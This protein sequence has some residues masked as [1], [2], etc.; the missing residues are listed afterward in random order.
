VL[1]ESIPTP[2]IL[3]KNSFV[4]ITP[5]TKANIN[6]TNLFV[7]VKTRQTKGWISVGFSKQT[8]SFHDS[9]FIIALIPHQILVFKNHTDIE[10]T[11]KIFDVSLTQNFR[12]IIDGLYSFS[13][14]INS[15]L[16]IDKN[17]IFVASNE[18]TQGESNM[19]VPKHN[20]FS[21]PRYF[22]LKDTHIDYPICD[23]DLN[24]PGRIL[25]RNWITF[26]IATT[27]FS[28]V[29]PFVYLFQRRST[30]KE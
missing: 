23:Q 6:D 8:N 9:L 28:H 1:V 30:S 19:T 18:A 22:D 21:T 4:E 16:I 12:D 13:F 27:F 17:F 3:W 2:C 29:D 7:K 14:S 15:S 10:T 11:D 20:D 25:A 26:S 24:L 5:S